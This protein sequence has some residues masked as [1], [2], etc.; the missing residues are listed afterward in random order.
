MTTAVL[1]DWYYSP[2]WSRTS[3]GVDVDRWLVRA[4]RVSAVALRLAACKRIYWLRAYPD[5]AGDQQLELVVVGAGQLPRV[6]MDA[7]LRHPNGGNVS[8]A[9]LHLIEIVSR[10]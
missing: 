1:R 9:W 3:S 2:G 8:G 7:G 4:F 6:T 10:A 5:S